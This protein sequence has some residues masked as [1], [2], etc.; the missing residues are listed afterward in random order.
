[1][2]KRHAEIHLQDPQPTA[3][4]AP[5]FSCHQQN[6]K[7]DD[8]TPCQACTR[9]SAECARATPVQKSG[10]GID[11]SLGRG[12]S[13]NREIGNDQVGGFSSG[14]SISTVL[15]IHGQ[16]QHLATSTDDIWFHSLH[17]TGLDVSVPINGSPHGMEP[18]AVCPS[19]RGG[20]RGPNSATMSES[21]LLPLPRTGDSQ[22]YSLGNASWHNL[23][24][25]YKTAAS[26]STVQTPTSSG[27]LQIEDATDLRRYLDKDPQ[28]TY[29]F[30]LKYF[31]DVHTN[32]PI[33]HVPSFEVTNT[34]HVLLASMIGLAS[35]VERTS[36]H[37]K[38]A[39]LLYDELIATLLVRNL[40]RVTPA[41]NC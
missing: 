18:W 25:G 33:L 31:V 11:F 23:S 9:S 4:L 35:W 27:S 10:V 15:A 5:C 12:D 19:E 17:P 7:C 24:Q 2:L 40:F 3:T 32:W 8:S 34:S 16:Q 28:A 14:A 38:L 29:R 37:L 13:D 20:H 22:T 39:P 30:I 41:C 6:L 36:D 26:S 21:S 1:M